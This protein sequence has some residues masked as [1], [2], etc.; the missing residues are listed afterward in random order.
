MYVPVPL[1]APVPP[2][3]VTV[4]VVLLPWQRILP[5]DAD[6]LTE[7]DG[8]VIVMVVGAVQLLASVT[9]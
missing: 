2:L 5:A 1:N 7:L 9:V 4:T 8:W 3:P 6:A